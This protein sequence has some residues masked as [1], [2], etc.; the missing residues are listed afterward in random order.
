MEGIR[1]LRFRGKPPERP[2]KLLRN[3]S[4]LLKRASYRS[5]QS[6][7]GRGSLRQRLA[8]KH[9]AGLDA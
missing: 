9:H 7:L 1:F 4:R 8:R 3:T 6:R 5:L 2:H